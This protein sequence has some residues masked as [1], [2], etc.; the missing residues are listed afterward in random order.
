MGSLK[1]PKE[2]LSYILEGNLAKLKRSRRTNL[3]MGMLGGSFIAIAGLF[4]IITSSGELEMFYG[5]KKL[6]GAITF[7]T[8]FVL[9][10]TAGSDLYT[11]NT[12]L[13]TNVIKKSMTSSQMVKNLS[14]IFMANF[15]GAL[16]FLAIILLGKVHLQGGG[17][18]VYTIL[19]I[20]SAK[21]SH[22]FFQAFVLGIGCNFLVCLAYWAC[23]ASS[24]AAN[25]I[26]TLTLPIAA[27][28]VAGFEHSVANMF[29]IPLALITK[30]T[31]PSEFS[32]LLST[33]DFSHINITNAIVYNFI[34]VTLGNFVG[35]AIFVGLPYTLAFGDEVK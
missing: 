15:I 35:G 20:G 29:L 9:V 4:Y 28:V 26:I 33:Y 27:F 1:T 3:I 16:I 8:G 10:L 7:T 23:C 12:M 2:N 11:S 34:P 30:A 18:L 14:F 32:S 13:I 19:S 6:M 25:K 31:L 24:S 5:A 21:M 17:K 22:S